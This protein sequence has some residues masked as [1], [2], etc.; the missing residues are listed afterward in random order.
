MRTRNPRTRVSWLAAV[1]VVPRRRQW[2]RSRIRMMVTGHLIIRTPAPATNKTATKICQ[3]ISRPRG[4]IMSA[5]SVAWLSPRKDPRFPASDSPPPGA[6]VGCSPVMRLLCSR[7]PTRSSGVATPLAPARRGPRGRIRNRY[8]GLTAVPI[9]LKSEST[10]MG[11]LRDNA[12]RYRRWEARRHRR[13]PDKVSTSILRNN[14]QFEKSIL[15][16]KSMECLPRAKAR[17]KARQRA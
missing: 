16:V 2:Q 9:L 12:V 15:G 3:R 14:F 4:N 6:L 1:M 10:D 5:T 17:A 7:I 11:E 13:N 8:C